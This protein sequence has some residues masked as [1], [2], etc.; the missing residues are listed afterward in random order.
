MRVR[1]LDF[2]TWYESRALYHMDLLHSITIRYDSF[3]TVV[4]ETVNCENTV[5]ANF[6]NA[7]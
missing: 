2:S 5:R 6:V 3:G 4:E 1:M 7:S